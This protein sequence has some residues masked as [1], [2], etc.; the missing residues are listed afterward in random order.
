MCDA[1]VRMIASQIVREYMFGNLKLVNYIISYKIIE[2]Y[3]IVN[4]HSQKIL[5][6]V[7]LIGYYGSV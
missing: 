1:E 3:I 2:K 5:C 7:F 6:I 4:S